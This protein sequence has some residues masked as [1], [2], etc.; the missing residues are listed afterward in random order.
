MDLAAAI[1]SQGTSSRLYKRLVYEDKTAVSVSAYQDSAE[2]GSLFEIEVT[3]QPGASL[4]A[5]EAAVDE[6]M[7]RLVEQGP[8]AAELEQRKATI[9]LDKLSA[10]E[11][12]AHVA[13]LLNLYERYFG[14]PNSFKRDLDRY[15][16]ATAEGVHEWCRKVFTPD[17]R[18]IVRV[19]PE[20]RT[21]TQTARDTRPAESEA[22]AFRPQAPETFQLGN[23]MPV[24]FWRKSELPMVTLLMVFRTGSPLTEPGK[25]G[26][27]SRPPQCSAKARATWTRFSSATR[28]SRLGPGSSHTR[29]TTRCTS[30]LSC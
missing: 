25:A 13:Y 2:L 15:R 23:G 9:E 10:M 18:A 29:D 1:L 14:E 11:D 28:C 26:L 27:P 17:A 5:I 6:E 8:G 22:A 21:T 4:E 3:A 20:Q 24:M 12:I 16:K 7:G 19:L 30:R